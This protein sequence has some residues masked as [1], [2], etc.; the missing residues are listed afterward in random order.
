MSVE[1]DFVSAAQRRHL[2]EL[3]DMAGSIRLVE[4]YMV[5][6][7]GRGSRLFHCYQLK[8]YGRPGRQRGWR[9]PRVLRIAEVT[10]VPLPFTP[11]PRYNP[12]NERLFPVVE[13]ALPTHDGRQR[14]LGENMSTRHA[15]ASAQCRASCPDGD[16]LA[17]GG[18]QPVET[19]R[20]EGGGRGHAAWVPAAR[21]IVG[22]EHGV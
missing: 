11:R 13:F 19:K 16:R 21:G 22:I 9:N 1:T 4:P 3:T 5:F 17:G 6:I 10:E 20:G 2:V 18:G 14:P 7:S 8:V 12:F 15:M